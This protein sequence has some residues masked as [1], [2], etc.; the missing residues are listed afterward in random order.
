M[1]T[2]LKIAEDDFEDAVDIAA[3]Y[4]RSGGIVVYPTDTVYGIGGDA[5]R[6]D[7]VHKVH[8]IKGMDKLRPISVMMP[9]LGMAEYYCETGIWEDMILGRYLPG[10]YTFI[11]RKRI[12]LPASQNEKLG[13]RIPESLFCQALCR[14]L[15]KPILT[16]SANPTG[17]EA[18]VRFDQVDKGIIEKVDLAIDGGATKYTA[19]SLIVDLVDR[20]FMRERGDEVDL[21]EIP[22]R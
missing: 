9:D 14:R 8:R 22:E 13:I 7:V 2:T 15:G 10:P 16:T 5:T 4:M 1:T 19:P 6:E 17:Q 20:K 12:E 11:M 21:V 3:A 18:P